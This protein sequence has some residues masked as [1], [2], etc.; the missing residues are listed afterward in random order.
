VGDDRDTGLFGTLQAGPRIG[1]Q[2]VARREQRDDD[3]APGLPQFGGGVQPV[4]AIAARSGGD[5]DAPSVRC[6]REGQARHRCAGLAHEGAARAQRKFAP[7]DRARRGHVEQ[8][9]RRL[10]RKHP[11]GQAG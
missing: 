9:P 8:W 7:L 10:R 6:Q 3:V 4:A 2:L 1:G 11:T 5:P